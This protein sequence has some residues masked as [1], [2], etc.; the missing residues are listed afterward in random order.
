MPAMPHT[1]PHLSIDAAARRLRDGAV[2]A[3]PTEA[4]WGLG[5]D[6]GSETAVLRLLALKQRAP[7]KGLILVAADLAQLEPLID[8]VQLDREA[9]ARVRASWPG[10]HTWIMP[11]TPA[12][13]RWIRGAHAG[14]AVRVSAHP[15]VSALCRAF[16]GA[17]VSSSANRSTQ[18]PARAASELDPLLLAGLD[19]IV[20]G[21]VG[22]LLQPTP[23]RDALSG[24]VLRD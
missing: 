4:V 5:C 12:V 10:P 22:T 11:A 21:E 19:G 17:L 2:I 3:C 23:I 16:G 18:P 9:G 20:P 15:L 13:P 24:R 8:W 7:D 14:V 6:P 1:P